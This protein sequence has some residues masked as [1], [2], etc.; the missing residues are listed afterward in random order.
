MYG[1]EYFCLT[2]TEAR[3]PVRDGDKGGGSGR[4]SEDSIAG[5]NP[6]DQGCRPRTPPEQQN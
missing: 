6:E 1:M 4:K 3:W 5:A 2:S